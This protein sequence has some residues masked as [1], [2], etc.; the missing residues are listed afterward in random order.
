[1]NLDSLAFNNL[2]DDLKLVQW[3]RLT[4]VELAQLSRSVN[5]ANRKVEAELIKRE[6]IKEE[7][8]YG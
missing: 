2:C 3:E 4:N 1:M 8:C 5:Y 6:M 7:E